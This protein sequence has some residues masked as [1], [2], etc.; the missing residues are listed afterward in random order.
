MDEAERCNRLA[1][2]V[3]G[4][5]MAEG[6]VDEII[7]RVGLSTWTA[8]GK[9]LPT[10]ATEIRDQPGIEQVIPLGNELRVCGMDASRLQQLAGEYPDYTWRHVG[11]SLE[12]V[13]IHL[14]NARDANG[15]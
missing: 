4:R 13:F 9:G 3:Y 2:I 8:T 5:L 11:S 1:Y 10:L 7:K 15:N 6:T 14:V 12:E